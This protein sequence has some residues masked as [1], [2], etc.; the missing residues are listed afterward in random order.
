MNRPVV[1][2][3]NDKYRNV[4]HRP[5]VRALRDRL[6]HQQQRPHV[7]S[8][9]RKDPV[10]RPDAAWEKV[11]VMCP[12]VMWDE[13]AKALAH[14][15]FAAASSMS[16]TR[17]ATPPAPTAS[18]GPSTT[19]NPIFKRRPEDRVGA[20]Q[21]DRLPGAAARR[22]A[23]DVLH[24]LSRRGSRPDRRGPLAQTA[25]A[26]GSA[27][28]PTRSSAPAPT[29]G[30]PTPATSRLRFSM[31]TIGSSGTTAATAAVSKSAWRLTPA[32]IWDSDRFGDCS[33]TV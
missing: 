29:A 21:S 7:D 11:A 32:R 18:R 4:V 5:K 16:R 26:I 27:L 20:A 12:H 14:V 22:L 23:R 1:I 3:R 19:A 13:H 10:L 33:R 25:S 9:L 17:S 2:H 31:A 28:P 24:R 15:V 6:R 8:A 30:T